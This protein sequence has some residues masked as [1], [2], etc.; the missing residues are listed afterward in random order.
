MSPVTS[1]ELE[2]KLKTALDETRLLILGAQVLFG[3]AFSGA[4]QELF[5]ELPI[6][7]RLIHCAGLLLFL[8]A[9]SLLIA[10]SLHHQVLYRGETRWGALEAATF[11]AGSSLLPLT[12][13]LGAFAYVVFGHVFGR[14]TGITAGAVFTLISLCQLYAAGFVMRGLD[15]R[16]VPMQQEEQETPLKTKIEQ[17][18]TEARVIIP[19]GQAL[20]GFQF[21]ATLARAFSELPTSAKYIHASGL[22]AIALAVILLMTPAALHR[23]A[24]GGNDN[25]TFLRIGS[26]LVIAAAFPLAMGVS[27]DVYVAF[28][29]AIDNGHAA[30]SAGFASFVLLMALWFAFPLLRRYSPVR[31]H[32][33]GAR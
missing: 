3:F 9:V 1:M 27:A 14:A 16:K 6:G 30:A 4:F 21:T 22:C 2:R 31:R 15:K 18:L 32:A 26:A 33:Q 20:L 5:G 25:E 13:G 11:F 28:L 19:G 10:P 7:S 12:L 29:K 17:L 23:I 24:Y 8:A